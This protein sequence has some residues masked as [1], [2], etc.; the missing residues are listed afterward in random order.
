[1]SQHTLAPAAACTSTYDFTGR[2][3]VVTGASGGIGSAIAESFARAGADVV[4]HGRNTEALGQV[5][6][7]VAEL[8]RRSTIVTG[9]MRDPETSAAIARAAVSEFGRFDILINNAG[10]NFAARLED[11]SVNAWNATIETN[12]SGPFHLAVAAYEVFKAN[13][14]GV[15]VNIG[16]ASAG[17][18]HPLRGAY[19]AAKAG[20]SSLTRTMAWEWSDANVRVNC[21]EPGAVLTPASRFADE[22]TERR[23]AHFTARRRVGVPQDIASMA[24]FLSSSDADFITGETIKVAGGP[25]T[26]SPGD[27]ALIRPEGEGTN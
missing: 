26:S 15:I 21:I 17:Y 19:A 24:L 27:V 20:L 1:M 11:L 9:N 12:L 4:L 23:I 13:G 25:P 18:A 8:G 10:G 3:A 22:E 16:S 7:R 6:A 2:C 14:G 5:A